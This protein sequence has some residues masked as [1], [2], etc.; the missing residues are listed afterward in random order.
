MKKKEKKKTETNPSKGLC[1]W[2]FFIV[3]ISLQLQGVVD[4][5]HDQLWRS[6]H[7]WHLIV[8]LCISY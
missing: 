7:S 6:E 3:R 1:S 4:P 8:N 2:V 5:W